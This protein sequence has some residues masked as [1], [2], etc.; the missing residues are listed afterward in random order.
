MRRPLMLSR[1]LAPLLAIACALASTGCRDTAS[2]PPERR[3]ARYDVRAEIL[4]LPAPG[5]PVPE[6]QA[7]HEAIPDFRAN[8][9]QPPEGMRAMVMP[10]PVADGLSLDGLAPG[11][12]VTLTFEVEYDPDSGMILGYRAIAIEPLDPATALEFA[13]PAPAAAE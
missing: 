5:D 8:I 1:A 10:F 12:K 6:I 9:L 3:T 2:E 7:R 13:A 4:A 11:A